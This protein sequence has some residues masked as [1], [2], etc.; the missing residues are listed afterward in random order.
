L[1]GCSGPWADSPAD[2]PYSPDDPLL[3]RIQ[4]CGLPEEGN[5]WGGT[6]ADLDGDGLLDLVYSPHGPELRAWRNLGGL[7]FERV[8]ESWERPL[9]LKDAHAI[10]AYDF[11]RDGDTDFYVSVGAK[12]GRGE[13]WNQLWVCEAPGV[14]TNLA[15]EETVLRDASGRGRGVTW[16]NLDQDEPVE[17]LVGNYQGPS[18]LFGSGE[19]GWEDWT[20]RIHPEPKNT[21]FPGWGMM[22]T[23]DLDLDGRTDVVTAR[24]DQLVYW[25]D[26]QGNL[27]DVS[28]SLGITLPTHA[29]AALP[30][31]DIDAD[32]DLD[33]VTAFRGKPW[34]L[35]WTNE[36]TDAAWKFTASSIG[37]SLLIEHSLVGASLADLDNDGALDLYV[38]RQR[39]RGLDAPNLVARGRGDGTFQDRSLSWGG[40]DSTASLPH[41]V[42]AIDL[43][44]DGDLDLVCFQRVTADTGTGPPIVVYE[45]RSRRDGVT[46]QLVSREGPAEGLGAVV[47]LL[48]A[49]AV[50]RQEVRFQGDPFSTMVAPIHFGGLDAGREL[51]IRVRWRR[52]VAEEFVL[53][54]SG[55][56]YVI[57]QGGSVRR[58]PV[59]RAG[60]AS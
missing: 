49:D 31:G 43:D 42:R 52:G 2:D 32:G 19:A 20:S 34:V 8:D 5:T 37:E 35:A 10:S 1:A 56:A 17:L 41:G 30:L 60:S 48:E 57:E 15:A 6:F 55:A 16:L 25:N 40:T 28:D 47:E 54:A 14:Y 59:A 24:L 50:R 46:L 26:S 33:L 36:L 18:A 38:L 7:R 44:A 51:R 4:D 53:P 3:V 23:G 45:N 29:F 13:G 58:V 39:G 27:V 22:S 21:R 11:D 9:D 12:R